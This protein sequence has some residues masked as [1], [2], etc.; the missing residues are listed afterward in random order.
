MPKKTDIF[1]TT[2]RLKSSF[3]IFFIYIIYF[4]T[5]RSCYPINIGIDGNI[6]VKM[7][8]TFMLVYGINVIINEI[9][10]ITK[11]RTDITISNQ[12]QLHQLHQLLW[13]IRS[14]RNR[15]HHKIL[16]ESTVPAHKFTQFD[17]MSKLCRLE[18][19]FIASPMAFSV[20]LNWFFKKHI[21]ACDVLDCMCVL[22]FTMLVCDQLAIPGYFP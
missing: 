2:F 18:F 14:P 7:I 4:T 12:K 6:S 17:D 13:V 3:F 5:R 22:R 10:T 8:K 20:T 1:R 9:T 21:M 15:R 19:E 11:S 16:K